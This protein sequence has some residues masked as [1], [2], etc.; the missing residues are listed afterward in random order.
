MTFQKEFRL[1]TL[2]F[3]LIQISNR[4]GVEGS[5]LM[6]LEGKISLAMFK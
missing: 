2:I 5:V 1:V 6:T 4:S 3:K